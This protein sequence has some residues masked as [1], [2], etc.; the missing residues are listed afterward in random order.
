MKKFIAPI[1]CSAI[2]IGCGGPPSTPNQ[3]VATPSS[4]SEQVK[5]ELPAPTINVYVENSGSMYG[6]V[7]GTTDFENAVYSYL[8]DIQ[9]A[10]LGEK[11]AN[12][13]KNVM[14][15]NYINSKVI[16]HTPDIEEFI[17]KLE[18]AEFRLRGGNMGTSDMSDI[19]KTILSQI[20]DNE[21]AIFVSDCILS[22]GSKYQTRDNAD[23]YLVS[24]GIGV[25]TNFVEK[26][27]ECQDFSVVVLRLMSQFN[28]TYYN[29]FDQR[30][31]INDNRPYYIWLMGNRSNLKKVMDEVDTDKIKGSG[32]QNIYMASKPIKSLSYGILPQQSIGK[33]KP[34]PANTKTSVLKAKPVKTGGNTSFQ[35]AIGVDF[36][37]LLLPDEYLTNPDN[38]S[39]SNV[40]YKL[41][42][43]KNKNIQSSY[44]HIL[45]LNLTEPIIN[46]GIVK[47]TLNNSMPTWVEEY[48]DEVGLDINA[49]GA[50]EKTYGLKYLIGG[51]YDAYASNKEQENNHGV[52]TVNIQ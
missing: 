48:T 6:Y 22:P 29:K 20:T 38:Y 46:K 35:L 34:D 16:K 26:I 19:L 44:T 21:I 51:V 18:P 25:K 37:E 41:E 36:S 43:V 8:S 24:N 12:S 23:E 33:F 1:L 52:I 28:G 30:T 5:Q 31:T 11:V 27:S 4:S 7:K 15:L 45:K 3:N 10:D 14:E 42:I 13:A 32:V 49:E 2:F 39:V 50:M 47:I 17:K 40:A 9:L